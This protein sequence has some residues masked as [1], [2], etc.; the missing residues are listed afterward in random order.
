MKKSKSRAFLMG[1]FEIKRS[2]VIVVFAFAA[3]EG[4]QCGEK[5]A[6]IVHSTYAY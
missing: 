1:S 4:S 2:F 3:W 5:L 6:H